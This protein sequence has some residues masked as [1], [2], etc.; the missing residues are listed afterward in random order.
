[1]CVQ[2]NHTPQVKTGMFINVKQK[3]FLCEKLLQ[4]FEIT[5]GIYYQDNVIVWSGGDCIY[6]THNG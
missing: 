3:I 1:M 2:L 5:M 4:Q 6:R